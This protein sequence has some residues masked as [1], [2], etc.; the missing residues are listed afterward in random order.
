MTCD[1]YI[2]D[3]DQPAM[4][5][6]RPCLVTTLDFAGVGIFP[7][8]DEQVSHIT[9]G[10]VFASPLLCQSAQLNRVFATKLSEV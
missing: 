7:S 5:D 6:I 2:F 9:T 3:L 8:I 1:T 10:L 4:L